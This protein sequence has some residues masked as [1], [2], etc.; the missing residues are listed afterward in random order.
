MK[1]FDLVL[2]LPEGHKQLNAMNVKYVEICDGSGPLFGTRCKEYTI[3]GIHIMGSGPPLESC[4]PQLGVHKMAHQNPWECHFVHPQ[5]DKK[6]RILYEMR[7][8]MSIW[9]DLDVYKMVFPTPRCNLCT[10]WGLLIRR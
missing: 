10:K 1:V 8:T 5:G 7:L 9:N 6:K 2:M 4:R 3:L